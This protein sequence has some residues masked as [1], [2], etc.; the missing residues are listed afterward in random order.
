MIPLAVARVSHSGAVHTAVAYGE[1]VRAAVDCIGSPCWTLSACRP[2]PDFAAE[3]LLNTQLS[4]LRRQG[5]PK[6]ET[7]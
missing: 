6:P 1:S 2:P 7:V 4:K 3:R 5:V